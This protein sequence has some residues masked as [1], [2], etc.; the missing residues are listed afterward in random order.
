MGM[1]RAGLCPGLTEEIVQLLRGRKIKTVADLAAADLE[2]VAQK[3]G[4]SYKALVALRR[5][6]LAQFSAFPLNGADLYE[7]LKT[8]TAILSTGIGS[9]DKLL[10]AGLYTGE[11]TEI[12]GGP[13]SGKTQVCLCVAANVAHSLQQNVLYVDSNGGMTASRLLQLLQA[14]TQD[15]EKQASALQRIQVVH[16]FD[17][18]QMLDMLQDLRGTMAQQVTNHL[19]RDRDSRRFK[20]ALGRS[21]SFVPSTRILLE[22]FEG[23]GTLGRSQRTVRL[24]K[25]PRQPTGLQEVIDI[26]T[27]GT[28]E[29]SPELPGKQT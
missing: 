5:V 22:V 19:T 20:P 17:I 9:L 16:S 15:E 29:Q 2:E 6:L 4:L 13:G 24:I 21:W 8:S 14:R 27:L 12:V 23:A 26:G 3:C 10:D 11:L 28:E 1:L 7:E 18:F 25:S